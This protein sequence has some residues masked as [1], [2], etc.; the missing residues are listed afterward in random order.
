MKDPIGLVSA[1]L[2]KIMK[3]WKNYSKY[4]EK[5]GSFKESELVTI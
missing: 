3:F 1:M 4:G 5:R 2:S